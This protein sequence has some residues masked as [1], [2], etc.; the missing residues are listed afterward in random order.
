MLTLATD[1]NAKK[2]LGV[3]WV[4]LATGGITVVSFLL[5]VS[6]WHWEKKYAHTAEW[7]LT[8]HSLLSSLQT[9]ADH[10]DNTEVEITRCSRGQ[11]FGELALV[12]N[13]PRAASAYAV[14]DVKCLGETICSQVPPFKTF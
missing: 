3:S 6:H 8:F 1:T 7:H 11:Y 13:K 12:T 14:G 10:A 9:K 4:C 2:V 5:S